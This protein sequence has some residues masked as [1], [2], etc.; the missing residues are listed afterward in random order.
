MSNEIK[1][2]FTI[3]H[4]TKPFENFVEMLKGHQ[5]EILADVRTLP[6]SRRYPHFN[7]EN[8]AEKLPLEGMEYHPLKA[9]GGLRNP[10]KDSINTAWENASFRGYA[11]YM[12]SS[13][14][15]MALKE[16]IDIA[17]KKRVAIMCAEGNPYHCH[18]SLIADALT[19][20]GI[21]VRHISSAKSAS[22]HRLTS[23]AKVDGVKVW[24][25]AE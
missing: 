3:G 13:D 8:L 25:P 7:L 17:D 15:E 21:E 12:Q 1:K 16:L 20:R 23:F 14:F 22:L 6:K 18:R 10:I 11:D 9:L 24:Y 19:A 2:I 4:S 5:I